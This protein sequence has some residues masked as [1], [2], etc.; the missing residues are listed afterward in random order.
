MRVNGHH[1]PTPTPTR[2]RGRPQFRIDPVL[3][4][5]IRRLAARRACSIA[6]VLRDALAA[7]LLACPDLE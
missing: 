4:E 5:A 6:Q 1:Q 2:Y 3:A 7:Y